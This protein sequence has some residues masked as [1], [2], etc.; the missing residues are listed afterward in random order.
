MRRPAPLIALCIATLGSQAPCATPSPIDWP[1]FLS[2]HDM[3]WDQLPAA[4]DEGAFTGNGLL[5]TM[6][7]M[8][9]DAL[10]F[11]LGR[12]DFIHC[13]VKSTASNR[14]PIGK[15]VLRVPGGIQG[16]RLRLDLWNATLTGDLDTPQ[17]PLQIRSITH[18]H[19]PVILLALSGPAAPTAALEFVP[20]EPVEVRD[21]SRGK[22]RLKSEAEITI[23]HP[24][25][26]TVDGARVF[27]RQFPSP[28]RYHGDS[29]YAVAW[30]ESAGAKGHRTI[31][32]GIGFGKGIDRSRDETRAA[33]G[34]SAHLP[35][36]EK[37]HRAWWNAYYPASFV[38]VPHE[39]LESLYWIQM[40][41]LASATRADRTPIDLVGPWYKLTP[42]PRIW[43][44]LNIQLTYWPVYAANRL[45][46]GESLARMIERNATNFTA[47][48]PGPMRADSAAIGRVSG[49]D[50]LGSVGDER[51]NFTW[52]L[53]N[54]WLQYRYAADNDRMR[55]HLVP[56]LRRAVNYYRHVATKE[57]DG[58]YHLPVSISPEYPDKAADTAYDLALLRWGCRTL[59]DLCRQLKIDDPQIPTWKDLLD[60]LVPFHVDGGGALMIGR[61]VPY[62]ESHRH[63]S[64]LLM[65]Y[66]LHTMT[67]E[68]QENQGLMARSVNHWLSIEGKHLGYSFTGACALYADMFRGDDALQW[69]DRFLDEK[70]GYSPR[71]N[72]MYLEAGPVIETPLSAAASL[73]EMLIQSYGGTIRVFP[74]IPS[75]WSDVAVQDLRAEGA[76]LVSAMRKGGKTQF[77][78]IKSLAGEPCRIKTDIPNPKADREFTSAN[79]TLSVALRKGEE[80]TVSAPGVTDFSITP[81]PA[82]P[83]KC[84]HFGGR[85]AAIRRASRTSS[86]YGATSQPPPTTLDASGPEILLSAKS[87]ILHGPTIT[88]FP[89]RDVIGR[90]ISE[91]DAV[92]WRLSVPDRRTY[93]AELL[94][95]SPSDGAPVIVAIGP[96]TVTAKL[97]KTGGFDAYALIDLGE[98]SLEPGIQTIELKPAPLRG[99][100]M[101]LK[102]IRLR[103]K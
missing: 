78:R 33:T 62:R 88:Y 61:D 72:T 16:G 40:Y 60:S 24:K 83:E 54:L 53:H 87:A 65:I 103:R 43:W 19:D 27:A 2:R 76:F 57:P 36:L 101:N 7:Y 22:G 11:D 14:V 64:H 86:P 20:F 94:Y 15:M 1:A 18:A 26:E 90:W 74:A 5:G 47:N 81:V 21:D 55:H 85:R 89:D 30:R 52:A 3:V 66:P 45:E 23:A 80:I 25:I 10:R 67:W 44:N 63:F 93:R 48:V 46:L 73:H 82:D 99:A 75:S 35:E 59:L 97:K 32:I 8:E 100:L 31:A 38:S 79:G 70:F 50:C 58:N 28:D 56:L 39:Q 41:K 34:A 6:A 84:N 92:S 95:G 42:W 37:S 96:Q 102:E 91:A 9:G 49:Y 29:G 12:S 98:L 71:A 13:P 68:Q 51:G 4:W 69:I 77:V 17:G